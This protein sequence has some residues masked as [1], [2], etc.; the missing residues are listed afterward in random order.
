M[1]QIF[2]DDAIILSTGGQIYHPYEITIFEEVC[3]IFCF[4]VITLSIKIYTV[5]S[6]MHHQ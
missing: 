5:R 1:S 6:S 4:I 2:V 3:Q